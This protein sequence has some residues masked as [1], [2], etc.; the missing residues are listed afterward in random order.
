[1]PIPPSSQIAGPGLI[2][3]RVQALTTILSEIPGRADAEAALS[4]LSER[5]RGV[6]KSL[7]RVEA[8]L[9]AAG[10]STYAFSNAATKAAAE[11][12]GLDDVRRSRATAPINAAPPRDARTESRSAT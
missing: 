3:L 11:V 12:Q 1:M 9:L 10:T 5:M 7:G 2:Q 4:D 6:G 8:A